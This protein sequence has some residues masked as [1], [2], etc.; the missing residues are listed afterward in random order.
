[1]P[2][3]ELMTC[4]L[5]SPK[6][7]WKCGPRYKFG[8]RF[9]V[10]MSSKSNC[11]EF[12]VKTARSAGETGEGRRGTTL[13]KSLSMLTVCAGNIYITPLHRSLGV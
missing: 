2:E 9:Q 12:E 10:G 7:I 5:P 8:R 13:Q 6:G 4:L 11:R 1:M 3:Q